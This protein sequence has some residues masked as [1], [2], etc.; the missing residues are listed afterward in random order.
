MNGTGE[1]EYRMKG[2]KKLYLYILISVAVVY[3]ALLLTLYCSESVNDS[4]LIHTLG[5]ARFLR[6]ENHRLLPER[7]KMF[8]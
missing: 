7:G 4:A 1:M 6:I 8:G 3:I 2:R 5:D